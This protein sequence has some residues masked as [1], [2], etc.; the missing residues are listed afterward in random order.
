MHFVNLVLLQHVKQQLPNAGEELN[1]YRH[2]GHLS[3]QS[4]AYSGRFATICYAICITNE[5]PAM[6]KEIL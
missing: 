6:S 2:N 5:L 1:T 4:V 3:L